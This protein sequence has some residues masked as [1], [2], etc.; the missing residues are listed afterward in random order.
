VAA[1]DVFTMDEDTTA[2]IPV[3]SNDIDVDGDPL[4]ITQASSPNGTV[5]I[6]PDGTISFTPAPNF[7]GP[8]TITY[9][10]SDGRG[11]TATATVA[12]KVRNTDEPPVDGDE[13][14]TTIGGVDTRIDVLANA[15]DPDGDRLSVIFAE[16][17]DGQGTVTINADGT[18]NFIAPQNFDGVSIIVYLISDGRGGFDF[19]IVTV[20]VTQAAADINA[21]LGVHPAGIPDGWLV[22]EAR[23]QESEFIEV[24]LIIDKTV[25]EFRA[26]NPIPRLFGERPLLTAV[27]GIS[28]LRGVG[29]LDVYGH[30]ISQVA[31]YINRIRDIR[32]GAD[33]LFDPRF[34]D[35]MVKSLTGFS[36]RELGTG[37]E[38]LMIESVV[39]DRVIYMELRDVGKEGDPPIIEYQLRTRDGSPLPE[40]IH[41]D[42]RGLAIIERPVDADE[43]RLVVKAIRADGKVIE[44]PVVIQGSTGEIELDGKARELGRVSAAPLGEVLALAQSAA[45]DETARLLAAFKG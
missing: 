8:A 32:F 24:P 40:W 38:Q 21:L 14:I 33:R 6:N 11:G 20:N 25:N 29:D 10:V 41:M 2:R 45:A 31:D 30:P 1:N 44:V 9:T 12:V 34:G 27:N 39:R 28:W 35:F 7:F 4:T 37:N 43:I 16:V 23:T 15:T 26:L 3:L 19:S 18:L 13:T 5:V 22:D 42:K 17:A 36:V